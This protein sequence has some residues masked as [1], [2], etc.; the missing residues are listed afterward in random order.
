VEAELLHI[1]G[2][3]D[4]RMDGDEEPNSFF[5][6]SANAPK[7]G[8]IILVLIEIILILRISLN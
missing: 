5:F 1:D 7:K 8:Y 4:G 2:W 3:K 6:N